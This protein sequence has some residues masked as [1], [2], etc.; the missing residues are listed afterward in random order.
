MFNI[1]IRYIVRHIA[2]GTL[3][4]LIYTLEDIEC[5]RMD[6][7]LRSGYYEVVSRS[8]YKEESE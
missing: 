3:I 8:L 1:K 4:P 6:E 7:Y 2:G 5:G